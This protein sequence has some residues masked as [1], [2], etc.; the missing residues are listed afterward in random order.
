MQFTF[1]DYCGNRIYFG[2][3]AK[4]IDSKIICD[5]ECVIEF[6]TAKKLLNTI[7]ITVDDCDFIDEIEFFNKENEI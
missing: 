5:D 7:T 2:E 3:K 4:K 6:I 1:C